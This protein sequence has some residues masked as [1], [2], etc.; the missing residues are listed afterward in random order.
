MTVT[1]GYHK[2]HTLGGAGEGTVIVASSTHSNSMHVASSVGIGS[3]GHEDGTAV[4][5]LV[6]QGSSLF[7]AGGIVERRVKRRCADGA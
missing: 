6:G 1:V 7:P 4:M 5:V 3:E 2:H